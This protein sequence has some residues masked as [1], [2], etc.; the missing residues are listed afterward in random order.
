MLSVRGL[1]GGLGGDHAVTGEVG[2]RT[3]AATLL[4]D[5]GAVEHGHGEGEIERALLLAEDAEERE[6]AVRVGDDFGRDDLRDA[7][8][9]GKL[10]GIVRKA[11]PD[12]NRLR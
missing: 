6:T 8:L 5:C 7:V 11:G 10:A 12:D 9:S 4:A 2:D 3:G 1:G